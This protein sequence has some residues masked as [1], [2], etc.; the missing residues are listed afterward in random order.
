MKYLLSVLFLFTMNMAFTQ[1]D[2]PPPPNP[3]NASEEIFK[4]VEEMPRFPGC[5]DLGLNKNDLSECSKDSLMS[6]IANNLVYPEVGAQG[7]AVVQFV[8]EKDGTLGKIKVVRDPGNGA[9]QAAADVI[10]KMNAD[11]KVWTP[12]KQRGRV[13]VVQYTLPVRFDSEKK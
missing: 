5:E 8:V 10:H 12:G 9:G 7:M 11:G 1:V 6:Y 2:V 4:I 3:M 13:V